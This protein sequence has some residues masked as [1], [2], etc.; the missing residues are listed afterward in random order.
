[1]FSNPRRDG[2]P[3]TPRS[4]SGGRST[5]DES[6]S[7]YSHDSSARQKGLSLDRYARPQ[8]S[9]VPMPPLR[10]HSGRP[11]M[12]QSQQV[13]RPYSSSRAHE[14]PSV[15]RKES[16]ASS[17]S[18][19][20]SHTSSLLDRSKR[21]GN[22]SSRTSLEDDYESPRSR[23]GHNSKAKDS[24]QLYESVSRLFSSEH[25]LHLILLLVGHN[26]ED[27]SATD[28]VGYTLWSRL[29]T[30]AGTLSLDVSNA[31]AANA[32]LTSGEGMSYCT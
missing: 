26:H 9:L 4:R 17:F 3:V 12:S 28:G 31:W 13:H 32:T 24:R 23:R 29:A 10:D 22:E 15:N 19:V 11:P 30:A 2:L 16:N 1:M 20:S 25:P 14:S 21:H 6:S 5:Q 7:S 18:V 8:R 27:S